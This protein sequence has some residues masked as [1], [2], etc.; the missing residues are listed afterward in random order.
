MP[1]KHVCCIPAATRISASVESQ[2]IDDDRGSTPPM[3]KNGVIAPAR[4]VPQHHC[5]RVVDP[6]GQRCDAQTCW[7]DTLMLPTIVP[8]AID[9]PMLP[10]GNPSTGRGTTAAVGLAVPVPSCP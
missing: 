5:A 7:N 2:V 10:V 3:E 8:I 1:R 4:F 6:S 9:S